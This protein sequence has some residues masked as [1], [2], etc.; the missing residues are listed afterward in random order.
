VLAL[1]AAT[2]AGAAGKQAPVRAEL[3]LADQALKMVWQEADDEEADDLED[4]DE[5]DDLDD[6]DEEDLEDLAGDLADEAGDFA[7][8]DEDVEEPDDDGITIDAD[9]IA[10]NL[11]HTQAARDLAMDLAG[12]DRARALVAVVAQADDNLFEYAADVGWVYGAEQTSLAEALDTSLSL[13]SGLI[14]SQLRKAG[15]LTKKDRAKVLRSATDALTDEDPDLMLETLADEE[16][17]GR[18]I[19]DRLA[20]TTAAMLD[21]SGA[22]IRTLTGLADRAD[23]GPFAKAAASIERSLGSLPGLAGELLA[24]M[25]DYEDPEASRA[26]FCELLASLPLERPSACA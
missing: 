26:A 15:K 6:F 24:D 12:K 9:A 22:A 18:P 16:I 21:A 11:S 13:R 3:R 23:R 5:A 17:L 10:A 14:G 8:S 7:D 4:F 19:A 25:E 20:T 1:A 2:V